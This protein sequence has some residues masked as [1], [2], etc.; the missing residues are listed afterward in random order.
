[1]RQERSLSGQ[2]GFRLD[3]HGQLTQAEV[4]PDRRIPVP[5][6]WQAA[7]PDLTQYSGYAWYHHTFV[8]E[9]DWL[10]GELLL[11]FG[12]VDYWCQVYLNGQFVGEHEGGYT[13]FTFPVG[14]YA[15][16]GTN[17]LVVR[18]YDPVQTSITI[19][20]WYQFAEKGTTP[21]F[22]AEDIPHGKQEW[23]FNVGGIWQD[24]R[25]TAVPAAY[26]QQ[27]HITPDIR[28]GTAQV[29]VELAGLT[30]TGTL[31]VNI[32]PAKVAAAVT[33][34][35]TSATL[36]VQVEQPQL[37]TP[38]TPNLYTAAVKLTAAAGEDTIETRFGFREIRTHK[39][40][41]LLNG[42]PVM[43]RCALDQDF[44][45]ETIYTVPSDDYLRD[46]FRKAK[47]L[48]LNSLRCHIKVPDPRYFD[49]ADEIGL[50]I[51]AEIPSWRTFHVKTTVHP[52]PLQMDEA[53]KMRVRQT[54]EDMVAADYNHPSLIIR[55]LVNEDWG[56]ALGL[57]ATDR[58]WLKDL[59]DYCK[60]LDPTRLVVDNSPCPNSWG[61]SMHVKTDIDDFHIY[62]NI[63]DAADSFE[64]FVEQFDNRPLWSFAPEY[65]PERTGHEPLI[66]S[67]FGNWGLPSL[68]SICRR[69]EPAWFDLGGW[70]SAWDGEPGYAR[71][72]VERFK[73]LGLDSLWADYEALAT[74]SQW[75]QYNALK[76]EIETMRRQPNLAGYVITELTDIYWESNGLM[77]FERGPKVYHD[78]FETFNTD[79]VVMPQ[80]SRFAYWDDQIFRARLHVSHYSQ[81]DWA[82]TRLAVT[83]AGKTLEQVLPPLKSGDVRNLGDYRWRLSQVHQ[84]E[85]LQ[86][87]SQVRA[88]NG[89]TLTANETLL[90]VL[91]AALRQAVYS[92]PIAVLTRRE[93]WEEDIV[94]G[95]T[96][97][98]ED[99]VA[100]PADATFEVSPDQ[101]P[102][103]LEGTLRNLG[104]QTTTRLDENTQLIVTDYP[105]KPMLDWV[106][107][108]GNMLFLSG[109]GSPFFWRQGRGGTFGGNWATSFSWLRPE[110]HQRLKVSNPL[111]LPFMD[112]MPNHV[113]LGLPVE[114]AAFHQDFLGGQFSGWLRHPAVHTVQFRY[115]Q[116]RVIM[117]TYPLKENLAYHP[118]A[119]AM[120]HDLIDY[121]MSDACQPTLAAL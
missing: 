102:V 8:L 86:L 7:F 19:P 16:A 113:I 31:Q 98:P 95:T 73:Q 48:G 74:A 1:M 106:R 83:L 32:G 96:P 63:P 100:S 43:L 35:Q 6:P 67:E 30:T 103:L 60:T 47:E 77:D 51:W 13:P 41:L 90:L 80:L 50:L 82:N 84:P 45:P 3:P 109:G 38:D 11:H 46:Q 44:Y 101:A 59:V 88:T 118:V 70:W 112:M 87:H 78:R 93:H 25:L 104:Y 57:S 81:S 52:A 58:A 94:V 119:I 27:V 114:D 68:K 120:L 53:L 36:T 54:F 34:G 71:G 56:T 24:V 2:W 39:G 105:T 64:Q 18:V 111:S 107:A 72:V 26:I 116:G 12:A 21:P 69:G 4:Q 89:H 33:A 66:V 14:R 20:R 110:I 79:D 61:L 75:H 17:T 97:M 28:T 15:Q 23:Y 42:Q 62:T 121:L 9:A 117:T 37:W 40:Q 29:Q 65:A 49:L 22:K 10:N 92:Q 85:M 55:T 91:P 99:A 5:L 115:G 76:F 108:G